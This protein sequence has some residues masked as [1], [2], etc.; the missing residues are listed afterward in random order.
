MSLLSHVKKG[1][2]TKLED[3]WTAL[4]LG[5]ASTRQVLDA[6]PHA[7]KRRELQRL[8][9]YIRDHAELLQKN[10]RPIEAAELLGAAMLAGASPGELGRLLHEAA[11]AAWGT[12]PWW[13]PFVEISGFVAGA[14]DMRVAWRA[15][16][17]LISLKDG[18]AVYH[19][20]GWGIGAIEGVDLDLMEIDVRFSNGRRDRF[21]M[22]TALDIFEVLEPG[23][24]RGLV[25]TDP[26]GLARQVREEPL[27]LLRAVVKRHGEQ[28]SYAQLK[29]TM[30]MLGVDGSA[31]STFWRK[32]RK[33]ADESGWFEITGAGIKVQIKLNAIEADPAESLRRQLLRSSSFSAALQR[34]R[35]VLAGKES[36]SEL[37]EVALSTLEALAEREQG[38]RGRR[39]A[40]WMLLREERG[41][42]PD[43]LAKHLARAANAAPV[44]DAPAL[45]ALFHEFPN[46]RDQEKAV[47][48]LQEVRGEAWLDE[49]ARE[50]VH[51]PSGLARPLVEALEAA[52][53]S[54]EL[55]QHYAGLLLRPSR[56]PRLFVALAEH[57]E[58]GGGP[59]VGGSAPQRATSMLQL[60]AHLKRQPAS[61]TF[62]ARAR[63]RLSALLA[64]GP[65][66]LLSRLLS[67]VASDDLRRMNAIVERGVDREI[68]RL[69]TAIVVER[70]PEIFRLSERPFWEG[71]SIWTTRAGLARREEELRILR[72]V[73]IP[74][75][76]EAIGRAASYGDL[77]ENSEWE[78]AIEDQRALTNRAQEIEA[79]VRAAALLE[80]AAIPP[81]TVA[82]G[83]RV[84]YFQDGD[85]RSIRLLGPWD[86]DHGPDIVSYRSPL[87][88][89]M[90]GLR[91]GAEATVQ[92]PS[93]PVTVRV[94]AI[95]PLDL[96]RL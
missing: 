2:W 96:A 72:D 90:L 5:D 31:F 69:F 37:R 81:D 26:A 1:D 50:L 34:V 29:I 58:K 61:D 43:A 65:E 85:E 75:N 32:A 76:S 30:G 55:R 89:G 3:D 82:P 67:G 27:E 14:P 4:M 77:S 94:L 66:P 64:E 49:A 11:E 95:E 46:L 63:V 41:R 59:G 10:E 9:P 52:G 33:L 60:A 86:T 18:R 24:P 16:E 80:N 70:A 17:Q 91:S 78:A 20:K 36:E 73:K 23:D 87:A 47:E 48:L 51:A 13:A 79:E 8:V 40:A 84:I 42:T 54:A 25:V 28:V 15:L 88:Q 35:D 38:D 92:L 44:G 12:E 39:F 71:E 83:T 93:G 53:R 21:P 7:A 62:A 56:N 6:L 57:L 22:R 19:S 74:E 68:D 45:W